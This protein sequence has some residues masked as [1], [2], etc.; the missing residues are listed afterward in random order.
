MNKLFNGPEY[1]KAYI[2]DLLIISNGNF[3]DYEF[4]VE[5]YHEIL[6]HPGETKTYHWS[7]YLLERPT[8]VHTT[9]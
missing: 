9:Y 3:E 1:I 2:E 8:K 6:C 7:T 5:W 4:L